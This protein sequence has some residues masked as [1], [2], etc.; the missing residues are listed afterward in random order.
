[1]EIVNLKLFMK[2]CSATKCLCT[3][4]VRIFRLVIAKV[5]GLF[6]N[7]QKMLMNIIRDHEIIIVVQNGVLFTK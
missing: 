7:H 3:E 1:M 6:L 4:L 5:L 2:R